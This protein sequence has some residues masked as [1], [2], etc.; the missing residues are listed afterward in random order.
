MSPLYCERDYSGKNQFGIAILG[1]HVPFS[2]LMYLT[3]NEA[4]SLIRLPG[5]LAFAGILAIEI[6]V[7]SRVFFREK[8]LGKLVFLNS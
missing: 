3:N 4:P 2:F 8:P 7:V 5:F 6:P 1:V